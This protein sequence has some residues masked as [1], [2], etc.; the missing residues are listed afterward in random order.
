MSINVS[1]L[2]AQQK[3]ELMKQL[4]EEQK[5]KALARKHEIEAYQQLKDTVVERVFARLANV[6]YELEATKTELLEE[7]SALLGAKNEL[8]NTN[9]QQ[10]SHTWT[11]NAGTITIITGYNVVDRWDETV[12]A[13]VTK[14]NQWLDKQVT[15]GNRALVSMIRD[16]LK[17]NKEGI[18]KANRVL[19]LQN[20]ADKIGDT[21]LIEAVKMIREAH[22]PDKTGT[23]IKAKYKDAIGNNVWL[24]LSMS[25]V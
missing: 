16:L 23:Y 1:L 15:D 8:Y 17:P 4:E 10:L 21:E 20:Q 25:S 2:T 19:D 9:E 24:G 7:F 18:L 22:R 3:A 5:A 14:V 13:G 12:S 11:N 6:S